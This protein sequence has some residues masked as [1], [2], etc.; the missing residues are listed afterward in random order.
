MKGHR[1]LNNDWKLFREYKFSLTPFS[2]SHS[3][4]DCSACGCDPNFHNTTIEVS[5]RNQTQCEFISHQKKWR[6][7]CVQDI[8]FTFWYRVCIPNNNLSCSLNSFQS[9]LSYH[10][11]HVVSYH[12]N[13]KKRTGCE[14]YSYVCSLY[15]PLALVLF[16]FHFRKCLWQTI[17]Q[18]SCFFPLNKSD[19]S[20]WIFCKINPI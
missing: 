2:H 18:C 17:F 15:V 1:Q 10:V 6:N 12:L 5:H 4:A 7:M 11:I 8:S 3:T 16:F 20:L 14:Y 13:K 19:D 9:L